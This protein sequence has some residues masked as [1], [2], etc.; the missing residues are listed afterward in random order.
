MSLITADI[1]CP[2]IQANAGVEV[3][4]ILEGKQGAEGRF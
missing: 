2:V 3:E 4:E 1:D